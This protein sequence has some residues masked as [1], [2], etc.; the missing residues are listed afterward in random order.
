MLELPGEFPFYHL[1]TVTPSDQLTERASAP[2]LESEG[3]RAIAFSLYGDYRGVA[4]VLFEEGRD[5]SVYTEMGNTLASR[6]A[7]SLGPMVMISPPIQLSP[8]QYSHLLSQSG[9]PV[10]RLYLHPQQNSGAP[11]R[12]WL[13][14][15][16]S[17]ELKGA[18]EGNWAHA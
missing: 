8:T 14:V 11:A 16:K 4:V 6:V 1:G 13:L 9:P 7:G 10:S 15:F 5:G 17:P 18:T 12:I 3:L 2:D